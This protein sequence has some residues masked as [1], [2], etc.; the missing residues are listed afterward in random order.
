MRNII[1][2]P[3]CNPCYEIMRFGCNEGKGGWERLREREHIKRETQPLRYSREPLST[4]KWGGLGR[5]LRFF[6]VKKLITCKITS[7]IV[8]VGYYTSIATDLCKFDVGST[9]VTYFF[10][11]L[12]SV[13]IHLVGRGEFGQVLFI[14]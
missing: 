12:K 11:W 5:F 9:T 6:V 14:M 2:R 10:F 4:V 8:M 13:R 7:F 3:P 1:K